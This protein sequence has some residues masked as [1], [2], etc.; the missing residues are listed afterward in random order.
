MFEISRVL[1]IGG[2]LGL[3]WNHRDTD[4]EPWVAEVAA[5]ERV[6]Y[7]D[8]IELDPTEGKWRDVWENFLGC[9]F[10]MPSPSPPCKTEQIATVDALV[11]ETRQ[12]GCLLHRPREEV[13]TVCAKV[14]SVLEANAVVSQR[15]AARGGKAKSAAE[16]GSVE[17]S[18]PY[19]TQA[20]ACT[21]IDKS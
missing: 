11:A 4:A 3:I 10:S 8:N 2:S 5:L 1:P 15:Q 20:Y 18:V 7:R 19:W 16:A 9:Y 14:R 12:K 13:D 6:F 17:L 21:L